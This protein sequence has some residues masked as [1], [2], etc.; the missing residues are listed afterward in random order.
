MYPQLAPNSHPGGMVV[1]RHDT[2]RDY[3]GLCVYVHIDLISR[4]L[5]ADTIKCMSM[6]DRLCVMKTNRLF[7]SLKFMV[8]I[9]SYYGSVSNPV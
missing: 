8:V 5:T 4:L 1:V 9:S 7:I 2:G 6:S 3:L